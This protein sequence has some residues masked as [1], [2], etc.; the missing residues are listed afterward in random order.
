VFVAVNLFFPARRQPFLAAA[1]FILERL[2]GQVWFANP[3]ALPQ[4]LRG[5]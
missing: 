5:I 2:A 4:I 1:V 3:A